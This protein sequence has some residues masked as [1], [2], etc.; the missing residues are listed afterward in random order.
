M[1][2]RLSE[3]DLL[4]R[5]AALPR[6]IP[7]END[8]WPRIAARISKAPAS[9]DDAGRRLPVWPLA[10]AASVVVAVA[11]GLLWDG[12]SARPVSEPTTVDTSLAS[13]GDVDSAPFLAGNPGTEIEYQA[14]FREFLALDSLA[15]TPADSGI[16][17]MGRGWETLR[18]VEIE[19]EAALKLNP[20]SR[21][22]LDRMTSLRARQ[23][24]LLQQIA[25]LEMASRRNTI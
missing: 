20:H 4:D 17:P 9:R 13:S 14:A 21:F 18:R 5:L 15:T 3:Q 25:A 8:A 1:S 12:Q 22:L 23:L 24:E 16:E 10:A 11:T 7:P 2:I 6:D 19:L